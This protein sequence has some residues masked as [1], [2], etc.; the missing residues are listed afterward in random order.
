MLEFGNPQANGNS[1]GIAG[2][3]KANAKRGPGASG[4]PRW[5]VFYVFYILF[6]A[7]LSIH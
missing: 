4:K 6:L 1:T 2:K 5:K 3:E 7:G